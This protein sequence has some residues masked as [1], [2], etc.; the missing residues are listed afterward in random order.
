MMVF[1]P[2]SN[3]LIVADDWG[4]VALVIRNSRYNQKTSV[5]WRLPTEATQFAPVDAAGPAV[6]GSTRLRP[7]FGAQRLRVTG[8][9]SSADKC[10]VMLEGNPPRAVKTSEVRRSFW[11]VSP[12]QANSVGEASQK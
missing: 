11:P 3:N 10:D 5:D 2:E 4:M 9:L 7:T 8:Q 12:R 1:L 6:P